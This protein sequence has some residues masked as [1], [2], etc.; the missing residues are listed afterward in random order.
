[1]VVLAEY[2][3]PMQAEIAK[4]MLESAGITASIRNEYM[5]TTIPTGAMPA[6]LVVRQCD[7][8]EARNLL[9]RR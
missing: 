8:D 3:N 2:N 5:S 4:S 6:Q 7:L 1:M 9:D